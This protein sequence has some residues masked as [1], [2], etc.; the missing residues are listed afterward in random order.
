MEQ[1]LVAWLA[2]VVAALLL[3]SE[4]LKEG[5]L[6]HAA[7]LELPSGLRHAQGCLPP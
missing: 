1:S 7:L 6:H 4:C 3:F 2:D 5:R